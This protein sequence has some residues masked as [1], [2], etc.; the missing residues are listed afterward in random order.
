MKKLFAIL[1]AV[2]AVLLTNGCAAPDPIVM[3]EVFQLQKGQ[4]IR[5]ACN[6]WYTD[7]AN[8]DCRNIQQGSFIPLGT[9][10]VPVEADNTERTITFKAL[11]KTF[12]INFKSSIRLCTMRDYISETFTTR[13]VDE[14][15]KGVPA[16]VRQRIVRGE[17]VPGMDR[18]QVIL[19]YGLPPA[20]RT[21]DLKNE[22][23][24]YWVSDTGTIRLVFRG[25]T[26]RQ[27]LTTAE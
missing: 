2:S 10:I 17:V 7:P 13:T 5:T 18:Q 16:N 21:P 27:I 15:L 22:T 6:L 9:P 25:D 8:V 19:A 26:V 1:A 12:T 20:A 3:S 11:G 4:E 14:M 24:I 23:W